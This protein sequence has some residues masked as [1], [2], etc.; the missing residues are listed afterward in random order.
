MTWR[1][2]T[3]AA[4]ALGGMMLVVGCMH[5][6]SLPLA[7]GDASASETGAPDVPDASD[8]SD[9]SDREGSSPLGDASAF[10]CNGALFCD[11][12]DGPSIDATWGTTN[13]A[14][15]GG[16]LLHDAFPS[17]RSAPNVLLAERSAQGDG[18]SAAY[19]STVLTQPISKARFELF[20]LPEE[21]DETA[22]TTVV[23]LVFDDGEATEHKVRLGLTRTAAQLQEIGPSSV[24]TSNELPSALPLGT[25]SHVV[26]EV[27]VGGR[28]KVAVD[29]TTAVDIAAASSW[30]P[31]TRTR[32]VA[33]INFIVGAHGDVRVRYDDV[34]FDGS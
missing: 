24:L 4:G 7:E 27:E 30:S 16:R 9:A 31:S 25:F 6:W 33:G 22:F 15:G 5:D 3:S 11:R 21:L 26:V 19:A 17:A 20:V 8:A 34:R 12:F 32:I 10:D 13:V 14:A 28:I 23:S 1:L 29:G 18:P 2:G